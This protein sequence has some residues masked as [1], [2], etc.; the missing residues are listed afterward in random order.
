MD[1]FR[2]RDIPKDERE[3]QQD[4]TFVNVSNESASA[5]GFSEYS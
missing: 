3:L 5:S 4:L 1:A 2:W